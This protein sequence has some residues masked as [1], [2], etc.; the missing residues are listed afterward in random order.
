MT[1]WLFITVLKNKAKLIFGLALTLLAGRPG[2]VGG[3]E[4]DSSDHEHSLGE[5]LNGGRPVVAPGYFM[6]PIAPGKPNFLAGSM[7]ELRPNHFH[8]G[9]DIKTGGGVNQPVYAAAD[10]Y[11][12]RLKQSSFGYGNVLYITHPNGLTTVYGHLNDFRGP[13]AAELLRR[14]YEKQ[15][16]EVEMFLP[17]DQFPVK[18]GEL[19]ALSGN[20]G[21]SAGPHLH[22][23]VRDDQDRQY[24]PLQWGGFPEIQD[25][26]APTLQAF[27]VEPLGIEARVKDVFAKALFVPKVQPGPGVTTTWADTIRCFGTVGLLVQGFDR[28]DNAWNRNGIQRVTMTVNGQPFYQHTIDAVPFPTG[29][30]QVGNFVDFLYQNTQGRTL[31]K[32]W[33]DEGN[34]LAMYATGATKGRLNVEAG[35]VYN[36]DI[37]LADSYNNQTPL[38]LVL[39]GEQPEYFKTRS[40]AVKKPAL[41]F[42]ITRNLLKA[43]VADP[44]PDSVAANLTLLRGNRRL[45]IRP[46]YTQNSENV[47]LYDLRAG[48]PDSIRFG[49]ITKKF[50]RQVM[51]PAG[52]EF[53][54]ATAH[55][56]L[57][58]GPETLFGN[59]YLSTA[60]KPEPPG[61]GFW[62]V[63]S[64]LLPLYHTATLTLKTTPP[65]DPQRTAIYA[66]TPKGGKAYLG[67]KWDEQGNI[68]AQ[69]RQ[70]ASYRILTD[71]VAPKASLIGRPGGQLLFRVG[72]DLSGLATYR[73][74]IGGKFRLLRFE[75]KNSTLF[76]IAT[77]TVGARLR[78]PAE[79]RLTDQAGNERVIPLS[80]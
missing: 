68:T 6:F 64:P 9:L 19:V 41:R 22:W 31:Q 62:T 20:T 72:D 15:S 32:L 46:S 44:S 8:G 37:T 2:A 29:T 61:H 49:S 33:V 28:F 50:D 14:Q 63:G 1:F 11:I 79:L 13:V 12:S 51:I 16:Y 59:L 52:K 74:L 55:L 23:E 73:L 69:I 42:E 43:V 36:V 80:L 25:H 66:A 71:T 3:Q 78:G 57:V 75:H 35:K 39:R 67:G 26:V 58:F 60:Y 38:H 5:M 48:L 65:A 34:D 30:R 53:S 70:F 18:R 7:G 76:T 27:A 17:K 4:A 21:G 54:Y 77:D 40:A 10:G 56:N 45:E 24:N 47:Y